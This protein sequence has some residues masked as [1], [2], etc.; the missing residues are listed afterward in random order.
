[1]L[2][3]KPAPIGKKERAEEVAQHCPLGLGTEVGAEWEEVLVQL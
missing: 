2:G 3:G 1:M